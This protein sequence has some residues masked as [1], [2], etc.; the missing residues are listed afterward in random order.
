MALMKGPSLHEPYI[1][2]LHK[3]WSL[4]RENYS[5]HLWKVYCIGK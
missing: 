3:I 4:Q 2:E 1:L 5:T